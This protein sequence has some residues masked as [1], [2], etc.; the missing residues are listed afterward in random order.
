MAVRRNLLILLSGIISLLQTHKTKPDQTLKK[1][2]K[3]TV[4]KAIS[5][6]FQGWKEKDPRKTLLS[7]ISRF[8]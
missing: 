4:E 8:L 2:K 7:I 3:N 5:L 6:S 1:K